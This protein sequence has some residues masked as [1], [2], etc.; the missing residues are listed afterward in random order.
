MKLM[1]REFSL[2][3]KVLL[4]ILC[5]I[6]V[7][8]VYFQFVDRPVRDEI[9]RAQMEKENLEIEL[10]VAQA[11]AAQLEKMK[12][13]IDR[14]LADGTVK[15]MSSYNNS[16]EELETLNK[17]LSSTLQYSVAFSNVTREGDQ[18]RRNFSLQFTTRDY[19]T[20]A[21]VISQ[22]A[23]SDCRC[24]I[25]DVKY[26]ASVRRAEKDEPTVGGKWVDEVYY[27]DVIRVDTSATFFETMYD[28]VPDDGLPEAK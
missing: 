1:T 3:S 8:L 24:L 13:E 20:M 4:I 18:I 14:L 17:V 25:G 15:L 21:R 26:S 12:N 23:E 19:N 5:I 10:T 28:G 11:K 16:K 6:L 27:F 9:E 7:V 2:R 22:L